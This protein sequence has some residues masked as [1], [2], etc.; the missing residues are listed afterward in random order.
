[1]EHHSFA[2]VG[3]WILQQQVRFVLFVLSVMLCRLGLP[4]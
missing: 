2:A 4:R 1:M 3:Q